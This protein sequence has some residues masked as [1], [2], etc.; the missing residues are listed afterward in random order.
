LA[1]NAGLWFRRGGLLILHPARGQHGSC[2]IGNPLIPLSRILEPSLGSDAEQACPR[3]GGRDAPSANGSRRSF[4]LDCMN[5]Q[6]R[7]RNPILV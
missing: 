6:D 5:V 4:T 2:Q 3:T 7:P 1:L